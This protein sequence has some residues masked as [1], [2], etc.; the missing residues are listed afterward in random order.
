MRQ[1][2]GILDLAV[3]EHLGGDGC[4]RRGGQLGGSVD[5]DFGRGDAAGLDLEADQGWIPAGG[6]VTFT[7]TVSL[8]DDALDVAGSSASLGYTWE[9]APGTGSADAP[10][11]LS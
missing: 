7:F 6:R 5:A 1:P 4:R 8:A 11:A 2:L 9:T 10:D 3:V